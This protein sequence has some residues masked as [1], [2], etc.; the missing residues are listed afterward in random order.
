MSTFSRQPTSSAPDV[1]PALALLG[2]GLVVGGL[3]FMESPTTLSFLTKALDA[4]VDQN[5][6]LVAAVLFAIAINAV[7]IYSLVARAVGLQKQG[8]RLEVLTGRKANPN[9]LSFLT[10]LGSIG[11]AAATYLLL[12]ALDAPQTQI[13]KMFRLK[14][15]YAQRIVEGLRVNFSLSA[16][17]FGLTLARSS[18]FKGFG[19]FKKHALPPMPKPENGLVIGSLGDDEDGPKKWA[20][21][22]RKALNGNILIT[23]SIGSGKTQGTILPFFDQILGN[24][25]IRPSI[26]AI[27]PK[28]TFIP[29]AL[30]II[31]KHGLEHHVLHMKL[32]GNVTFNPIA[33]PQL[34]KGA[35]FLDIAQMIRTAASELH[36]QEL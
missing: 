21:L 14:P 10:V 7:W 4:F 19:G 23:G 15:L 12:S 17:V 31:K 1:P 32:G 16:L 29:Q 8:S 11:L 30:K 36:G 22:G 33:H 2:L 5:A 28:G 9:K 25:P 3:L 6:T 24:F 20:V 35:S 13:L 26:L 27:D 34:L 18:L